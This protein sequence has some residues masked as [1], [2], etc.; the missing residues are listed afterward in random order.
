MS[1]GFS[2]SFAF[3]VVA[4][5]SLGF[6][7]DSLALIAL[8]LA[9]SLAI[10]FAWRVPRVVGMMSLAMGPCIGWI[11]SLSLPPTVYTERLFAGSLDVPVSDVVALF[12]VVS[13]FALLV[14]QA[15]WRRAWDRLPFIY[16]Y[17]ALVGAHLLSAFSSARPDPLAV[18][19]FSLRPV[20]FSYLAYVALPVLFLRTW[21]QVRHAFGWFVGGASVFAFQGLVSLV[22]S[23]RW[24]IATLHRARPLPIF[25]VY[26]IG[27]NHNVLA[28]WLVVAAPFALA[29]AAW[30]HERALRRWLYIAAGLCALT[31][32]LTFA[33]SAWIVMCLQLVLLFAT[34]W[35]PMLKRV[36]RMVRQ[37]LWVALVPLVGS[38]IAFS[39]RA[40]VAS[41]TDARAMLT[42]IAW[43]WFLAH[44]VVGA[45][46]GTF[47]TRVDGTWSYRLLFGGAMDAH[48]I[49]QKLLAETGSVGIA[50]YALVSVVIGRLAILVIR[51]VGWTHRIG[52]GVLYAAVG[53]TGAWVY[54]LFN[55]TYW[56]AKLWLPIGLFFAAAHLCRRS[57][58]V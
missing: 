31:A 13:L 9:S 55:T 37:G 57:K 6:L 27:S 22:V 16:S 3:F 32:L 29:L 51:R 30:T 4:S 49:L 47:L 53:M 7:T 46:A 50:A 42:G 41:S 48:G 8:L 33:R 20:A 14:R 54:Q 1:R 39:L 38:M 21:Q 2:L 19:K 45:G 28:E 40:E 17:A 56:S 15:D 12:A 44:P 58:Y 23:D 10:L 34:V 5:L 43:Q 36:M 18:I 35:R 26:P 25:G 52:E 24:Q 11:W